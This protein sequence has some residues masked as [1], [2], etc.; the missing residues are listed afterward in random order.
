[1][2]LLFAVGPGC[3]SLRFWEGDG[4]KADPVPADTK[5]QVS[6]GDPEAALHEVV[7]ARIGREGELD[8]ARDA[9]LV[10][11][12]PYWYRE[13]VV[14]P[15][16]PEA[17]TLEMRE[18]TSKTIPYTGH[19]ELRQIRYATK[20]HRSR[21]KAAQDTNFYR[22]FGTKFLTYRY[23]NGEWREEGSMFVAERKEEKVGGEWVLVRKEDEAPL[24]TQ[25]PE[26]GWLGQLWQNIF[27]D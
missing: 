2:V 1:M 20:L 16:G 7:R 5:T 27:G 14:Y 25:E 15:D 11:A 24:T 8:P 13:L 21:S 17:Y 10:D 18:T 4:P 9:N 22:S 23:S 19:V 12:R 6:T 3:A 26:P